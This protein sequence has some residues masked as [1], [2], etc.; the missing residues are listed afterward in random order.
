MKD[1]PQPTGLHGEKMHKTLSNALAIWTAALDKGC[2]VICDQPFIV[3]TTDGARAVKVEG[4]TMRLA[5]TTP[6][7]VGVTTFTREQAEKVAAAPYLGLRVLAIQ[8]L[9]ALRVAEIKALLVALG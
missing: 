9:P 5:A 8:R 4:N 2:T 1:G 7:L 6:E 3:A